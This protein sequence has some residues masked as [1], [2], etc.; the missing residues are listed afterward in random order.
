MEIGFR[1]LSVSLQV[2]DLAQGGRLLDAI[3]AA[4]PPG[5]DSYLVCATRTR[6]GRRGLLSG[7]LS[8]Q[9]LISG[10]CNVLAVRVV[11]PGSLGLPRSLL[12]PVSGHPRGFRSGIPFLR[13]FA[14]D[15]AHL[16]LLYVERVSRYRFRHSSYEQAEHL[17]HSGQTYCERIERELAEQ[18]G[19]GEA[20]MDA[21][22]VVSDDVPKEIVIH[23]SRS[24]SRLIYLGASERNLTQRLWYG[25]PIEQVLREAPCDVAIYRGAR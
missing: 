25:N 14:P 7:T 5:G 15:I 18:L 10:H 23:A 6:P 11:H 4:V 2:N 1:M 16:H 19:L 12:L 22:V 20:V 3:H 9:L 24:K 21:N 8:E 13:L 17:R